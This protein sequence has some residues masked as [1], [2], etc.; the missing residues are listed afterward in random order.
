MNN[1]TEKIKYFAYLRKSSEGKER[2]ALSIPA[3]KD[4]LLEMFGDLDVEFIEEEK[5]AFFPH[6]RPKFSD[7]LTRLRSGERQGLLAWHPDRLSRNEVDAAAI[8]YMLRTNEIQDLKF[9]TYHFENHTAEGIWMLQMALSQSQYESAKKGPAVKRGLETKAKMG[10]FPAPAPL[11]YCNSKYEESGKKNIYTDKERLPLLRKMVDLM[12]AGNHS[13]DKIRKIANEEWGFRTPNGKKMAR[14]TAYNIFTRPFYYGEF[15]YPAK[16]GKWYKGIHEPLMTRDEYE[17]I[18][19]LLGR[20]SQTRAKEYAFA[21]RGPI[22][23]GECGAMVTAEHKTKHSK[24]GVRHYTLYHC[25]K[26]KDEN[27]SQRSIQEHELQEQVVA[28]LERIEIPTDFKKWALSKL[29][30]M[31]AGEVIDRETTYGNQRKGYEACVRRIDNLIDMRAGGEL[32]EEEFMSRKKT[33]LVEKERL[34]AYLQDT[35][36]R[37]EKWLDIAERGFSFAE[38]AHEMFKQ[39]VTDDDLKLK[40]D[41]FAALGS[42]YTLKDKKLSIC[43]D[44]LLSPIAMIAKDARDISA[45]FEPTKTAVNTGH[46]GE[47]YAESPRVLRVMD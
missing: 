6:N 23:C 34:Q 16:S 20:P 14:S 7:M 36:K 26:R 3:Q 43:L 5:S 38:K 46:L 41:V 1:K 31:H 32:S 8:T 28:E 13:P 25:T 40:M 24:K 10:I 45:R 44:N 4:K 37:V 47:I 30:K 2:Q 18:Q 27:C 9:A 21:F 11:G 29:K 35:D 15:E 33:L 42:N 39:A 19:H 17:H 12:L 22:R